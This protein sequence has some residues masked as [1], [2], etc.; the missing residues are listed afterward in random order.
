MQEQ[1]PGYF[2]LNFDQIQGIFGVFDGNGTGQCSGIPIAYQSKLD[3]FKYESELS[4]VIK[5][6][7]QDF[8]QITMNGFHASTY[9]CQAIAKN[10]Q[11]ILNTIGFCANV[12]EEEAKVR[13]MIK[14]Y[15]LSMEKTWE[16]KT[17]QLQKMCASVT[18]ITNKKKTWYEM[19]TT[20]FRGGEKPLSIPGTTASLIIPFWSRIKG[21]WDLYCVHL[22]NSSMVILNEKNEVIYSSDDH[23]ASNTSEQIR[24]SQQSRIPLIKTED[25]YINIM[26]IMQEIGRLPNARNAQRGPGITRAF[27][28]QQYRDFGLS[29]EPEIYKIS[30][31]D[32]KTIVVASD[33]LWD[34]MEYHRL[35]EPDEKFSQNEK[36]RWAKQLIQ[37]VSIERFQVNKTY[38][39]KAIQ[40]L[41]QEY[42]SRSEEIKKQGLAD[43]LLQKKLAIAGKA[44]RY[45]SDGSIREIKEYCLYRDKKESKKN[46]ELL[47]DNTTVIAVQF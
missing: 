10:L 29:A 1:K 20:W 43:F 36:D 33:G 16:Q 25:G 45:S 32:A 11:D 39:E 2:N 9:F 4:Y 41:V 15:C 17:D 47:L 42:D 40:A 46:C 3:Q 24:V 12:E 5:P 18:T 8:I 31:S 26:D 38:R 27:G 35:L 19:I 14:E 30:L 23:Q 34:G 13:T 28:E 21:D 22:G 37:L 7:T 6:A 44:S